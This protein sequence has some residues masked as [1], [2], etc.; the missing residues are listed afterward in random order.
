L[1]LVGAVAVL[2]HLVHIMVV[3]EVRVD[4]ERELDCPL[5]LAQITQLQ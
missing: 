4:L 5:L 2:G 1:S 3:V